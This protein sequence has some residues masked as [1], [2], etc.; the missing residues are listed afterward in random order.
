[1]PG[2]PTQMQALMKSDAERWKR[3]IELAKIEPQ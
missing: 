1:L 3:Y 2:S